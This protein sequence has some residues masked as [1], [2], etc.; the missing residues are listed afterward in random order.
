MSKGITLETDC[1]PGLIWSLDEDLILG[2]L[3]QA[4]NNAIR[5]TRDR[6]R[7]AVAVVDGM[8]EVRVEDNGAGFPVALLEAGVSAMSGL[9][10]GVNF[11]TNSTGLGLYFSSVVAKM[12]KHRGRCGGIELD[13]GGPLQGGCFILRL[14]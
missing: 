7:L 10:S 9:T 14:P 12:H 3:G 8:L 11:A 5:Y 1:P 13:N 6:I 4:I 2:V